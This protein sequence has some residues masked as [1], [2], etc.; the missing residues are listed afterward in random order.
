PY[1]LRQSLKRAHP[2]MFVV[3]RLAPLL[4]M[5]LMSVDALTCW[6]NTEGELRSLTDHSF[7]Y[8]MYMP[9]GGAHGEAAVSPL[10][11]GNFTALDLLFHQTPV[12]GVR[13]AC[14]QEEYK[15]VPR[16]FASPDISFRCICR[17]YG[18]NIPHSFSAFLSINR[19]VL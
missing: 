11:T 3:T 2:L 1:S 19:S 15:L 16:N 12:Y 6:D 7:R 4:S 10:S 9:F 5:L 13:V 8:C 18:C 14:M 17:R